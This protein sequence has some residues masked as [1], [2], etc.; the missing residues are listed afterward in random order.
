MTR[1]QI[2]IKEHQKSYYTRLQHDNKLVIDFD[3]ER[4][5]VEEVIL[6]LSDRVIQKIKEEN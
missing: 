3:G 5:W 6:V 4:E 2:I 1:F